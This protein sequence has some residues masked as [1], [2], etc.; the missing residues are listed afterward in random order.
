MKS[1]HH[2]EDLYPLSSVQHGMLFHSLYEPETGLYIVQKHCTLSGTLNLPAFERAW[3][4]VMDRHPILRTSFVW[5]GLDEPVQVV[6][7]EAQLILHKPDW[8]EL[9]PAQQQERL[10]A[11]LEAERRRGFDLSEAPLMR[12]ALIRLAS[13]RYQFVWNYHHL[14]LDGWCY[15]LVLGEVFTFY[16]AFSQGRDVEIKKSRPFRDYIAWLQGQDLSG[17]ETFWRKQLQGITAPTPLRVDQLAEHS[18]MLEQVYGEQGITLTHEVTQALQS[19]ARVNRLTM[20]TLVQGAWALLLQRYSG[21]TDVVFGE[22]VS[23]R[24]AELEGFETMMGVFINTL[25]VRVRVPPE[26]PLLPW[27][28]E[29]QE[30]QVEARQYEHSPLVQVQRWSQLPPG[31]PLFDSLLVYENYPVEA[32]LKER[33]GALKIENLVI[34]QAANYPITMTVAPAPVLALNIKYDGTRFDRDTI[35][36]LLEHIRTLLEAIA[37]D[38]ERRL[39]EF[40]IL[41]AEERRRMLVEWNDTAADFPQGQSL[42][43]LFEEQAQR[44]PEAVALIFGRERLTYRELNRR[45]DRLASYLRR[46]GVGPEVLV[47]VCME[48]TSEMVVGL[49]GILKAGGAYV[50][51]DPAYPSERLKFMLEDARLGFLLTQERLVGT[52]PRH[53]A[54]V[55]RLDA[56]WQLIEA[57]GDGCPDDLITSDNLAYVIYTS[58]STGQ[59]KGVAI[60]HHSALTLVHWTRREF[61]AEELSGVLAGTSIIFD[62]S[63]FEL[64]VTLSVGGAVILAENA[65]QL[66]DLPAAAEVRLINTVP[67]AMT[68]LIRTNSVPDT[69]RV[70]NLAGEPLAPKLVQQIHAQ[71]NVDRVLNL[72]GPS[73]DTTYTTFGVME[74]DTR[75]GVTIGRPIAA[76]QIYLLDEW[77]RPVPVGVI[78]ELYIGGEGLAR[79][80]LGRPE[81]T[82]EKFIAN[83]FSARPGTRLYRTGDLARYLPDGQ[84]DFLGR[85]DHQVKVRGFRI[86]LGEI[87]A[88]LDRHPSVH[89]SVVTVREDAQGDK[90]LVAYVVNAETPASSPELRDFIK[91]KLPAYMVPHAFV[92]LAELPLTPNGKVDRRALPAPGASDEEPGGGEYRAPRTPTQE[93]LAGIW[94]EV[95][96]LERVG[97][98]DNFFDLGGHSLHATQLSSRLRE[99]FRVELPLRKLFDTPLLSGSAELIDEARRDGVGL[100]SP[101]LSAVGRDRPLPLSFA[102]QRLWFLYQMEPDNSFYNIPLAVRLKGPL[103]VPVFERALNEML[104]RHESLRTGFAPGGGQPVQVIAPELR[105]NFIVEDITHLL[106]AEREHEVR[107]SSEAQATAPFDL[108]EAP[109]LRVRLLRLDTDEHA[110]LFTVHHIIADGWSMD[111]LVREVGALYQAYLRGEDSPLEELDIQY[112]DY[113]VW[114]RDWLSGEVL[115]RQVAYWRKQLAGAPT[116]L[117]LPTDKMRPAMLSY[118]GATQAVS[119]GRELTAKLQALSRR[120]A[121]TLYMT[122]LAA[123][124][125]LLYRYSGQEQM[126][127]GMPIAN[128]T[129]VEVEKLIGF[130]VNTLVVRGEVKPDQ[131]FLDLLKEVRE[132]V[133]GAYSNQDVPFEKVVEALNPER[134]MS[135]SPLFQVVLSWQ[136]APDSRLKLENIEL[137]AVEVEYKAVR[138]D[139]ELVLW[140]SDGQIVGNIEYNT[141]LYEAETIR[142]MGQHLKTLLESIVADPEA[143]VSNLTML[144]EAESRQLLV[145]W[146]ETR[147]GYPPEPCI[148]H[149]FEAQAERTPDALAVVSAGLRL[150]YSELNRRA[151][152][153]AHHLRSLGVGPDTVVGLCTEPS[154][155]MTVAL[156]GILKAGGAYLPIEPTL[157]KERCDYL[158]EDSRTRLLLTTKELSENFSRPGVSLFLL[159]ADPDELK[160]LSEENPRVDVTQDNLAYVI[161]TSGSMGQPKGVLLPHRGLVN[162]STYF[163]GRY[164]LQP[165]DRVLQFA[166]LSFDVAAEELF[167]TWASG[168]GVVLWPARRTSSF[169]ALLELVEEEDLT[170]LNLPAAYWHEWVSELER[171]REQIP[172]SLRLMIVGSDRVLRE[173]LSQ[174]RKLVWHEVEWS[175]AYGL[176]ET[177]ITTTIHDPA[178]GG[179]D[180]Q[181]LSVPIGR[182]IANTQVYLL[183]TNLNPVPVGIPGE[184][185]VGGAGLARGYL[186]QSGRTAERFIP[187]PFASE[188]GARIYRTGD[189]ARYLPDGNLDILGRAD[190]Q[191]KIRGFRIELG[192]IESVLARHAGVLECVVIARE[193]EPGGKQL[194]GYIVAEPG[195]TPEISALRAYLREH[196]PEYMLPSRFQLLDK[197]PL[198]ANGKVDRGALP[199][200]DATRQEMDGGDNLTSRTPTQEILSGIWC[201]VLGL[202]RVGL[203]DNFFDLG[204]HSLLATQ[205]S[206]RVQEAFEVEF[207]L[208]NFFET[209]VLRDMAEVLEEAHRAGHDMRPLPFRR[210]SRE[211]PLPLSHEQQRLWF[212]D[213][214]EPGSAFFN[215]PGA[216]RLKGH[217]DVETLERSMD[218]IVRRHESLRTSFPATD[219]QPVQFI[220]DEMHVNLLVEDL[221]HL[222]QGEAEAEAERRA[223]EE[224]HQPFDLARGPL[225]R[226]RLLRL[227]ADDH[228][229][230]FTMHH[231]IADGWSVGVLMREFGTLYEA[232]TKGEASPLAELPFQYVDYTVWQREWLRGAVLERQLEFWK[233]HL[234]GAPAT[235]DLPTDRPR[236]EEQTFRG[237]RLH[238]ALTAELSESLRVLSR[239][240]GVTLFMTLFAGFNSLLNYY[241]G[242]EDMV[243]STDLANR[244]RMEIEGLIGFFVNQLPLRTDLAGDPTFG[245]LLQRVR[246]VALGSYAHEH[247]SLDRLVEALKIERDLRYTPLF[248]A[249]LTL[250]NM[251]ESSVRL[252]G[253]SISPVE[254]KVVTAQLDLAFNLTEIDHVLMGA[255]EYNTDLFDAATM[256]RMMSDFTNMLSAAVENPASRLSELKAAVAE[257]SRVRQ[258]AESEQ[259]KDAARRKLAGRRKP[260]AGVSSAPEQEARQTADE[261]SPVGVA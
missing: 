56:D 61:S 223:T 189:L 37:A 203:D 231:I 148:H 251:P 260:A 178:S 107:R 208:H 179:D 113:A 210:V 229:V 132:V 82:A 140:E 94:C 241:S 97:L 230:L 77:L 173:R 219:G 152:R 12:L 81:L 18:P 93:M 96:G 257:Q 238:V 25:P 48:R 211:Q 26:S 42:Q 131:K 1:K 44:T 190:Q 29:L 74:R 36:R 186:N 95:L 31:T 68:E 125:V 115:E 88:V 234:A 224:S 202:E 13:D 227:A 159:D 255:L 164:G 242:A 144:E 16:E 86:E 38:P 22:V 145:E 8:R 247:V 126:L 185:Y 85:A 32:S 209:P 216:A 174:W 72:Y 168:A 215:C 127:V 170:V 205:A 64:F 87:E 204:G 220:A 165:Q 60:T 196:L 90:R 138:Y 218:E 83:P 176:S 233:K 187:D 27:L 11:Y 111:V 259:L 105:L 246:A 181:G 65:L 121:V 55:I 188:A 250:Q 117:E 180:L 195:E 79:G 253:L 112:A 124:E 222:S 54:R 175:N 14:I 19:L 201:E 51:L 163:A 92:T 198:T 143:R 84:I 155:E 119:Y 122:V 100:E 30:R 177:T 172:T 237:A 245:E 184:L 151:N 156:L 161:Y 141:D 232:F 78:G 2:I 226:V 116:V 256:H 197:M 52:L 252:S 128:R 6:N 118:R 47:G 191:V 45:A 214:L 80:Y 24:P 73:E 123:F 160:N 50:P 182:P 130:F 134:D 221:G 228:V 91:Q 162:H 129:R 4:R 192:E 5:E 39:A 139:I 133:L 240:E 154:L 149:L 17:A 89:Q 20:Y 207:L 70:I 249:N 103:D 59:P 108:Q 49:L 71:T 153:L 157:P 23:G 69:V 200:P 225:L 169:D 106:P 167:P 40:P 212:L 239:R 236:A 98:D 137:S 199:A 166:S 248:Q 146:N 258:A 7:R 102:Q 21:D 101:P 235:L 33:G 66:P 136:N 244:N 34:F 109:L 206:S 261:D 41:T 62:L 10:E 75:R 104:R 243:V 99:A 53:T 135:R 3:Q 142:R 9:T 35:Q 183:D 46:G 254:M 57:A 67:S 150:T 114:Q 58:G 213:Q 158:L 76:T 63:V 110:V 193:V 171:T 28:K 43:K 120:E 15:A 194:V 217:L 147:V